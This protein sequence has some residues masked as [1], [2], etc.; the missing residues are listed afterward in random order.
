MKLVNVDI[1]NITPYEKNPRKNKL[2][3]D[4]VLKSIQ[5]FG[6][7]VPIILDKDNV[8][9]AGHTRYEAAKR[10][11]LHEIP[12]IYADDLTDAQ[13]KAFRIADNRVSEFSYWDNDFLVSELEELEELGFDMDMTG[14]DLFDIEKIKF[15]V[16]KSDEKQEHEEE[17]DDTPKKDSMIIQYNIIFN[18]EQ[19]QKIWQAFLLQ[20]K[21]KYQ[22][23]DTIAERLIMFIE[24]HE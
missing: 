4:K 20:L 17:E 14:F 24:E 13:I 23:V 10:L 1:R 15:A 16:M 7:K 3:I 21:Q 18:N 19:E 22:D 5:E 6:F 9:V 2:A 11:N 12:A 8:I